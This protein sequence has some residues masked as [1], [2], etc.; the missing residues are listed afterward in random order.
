MSNSFFMPLKVIFLI[1]IFF[2]LFISL[3]FIP[4]YPNLASN[5][6]TIYGNYIVEISA[7]GYAWPSPRIQ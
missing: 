3:F 5:F 4:A 2:I 1:I 7:S 6:N